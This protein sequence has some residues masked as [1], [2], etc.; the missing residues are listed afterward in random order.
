M[1]MPGPG[2]KPRFPALAGGFLTTGPS[3][4]SCAI[5]ILALNKNGTYNYRA[6]ANTVK[7]QITWTKWTNLLTYYF[8][9][10]LQIKD[11]TENQ[12]KWLV[13]MVIQTNPPHPEAWAN[14][15]PTPWILY[16]MKTLQAPSLTNLGF[17]FTLV[18]KA[19]TETQWIKNS[20][21]SQLIMV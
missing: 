13:G 10:I 16:S 15:T 4:R 9:Q 21:M 6:F 12:N 11:E 2:I 1:W 7:H 19:S 14:V 3:G 18:R 20:L 17:I 5:L 8:P